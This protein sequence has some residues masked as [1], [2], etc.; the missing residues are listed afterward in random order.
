[1]KKGFTL[2]ELMGVII[3][4]SLLVLIAVPVVDKYIKQARNDAGVAQE[5]SLIMAAKN[6]A[7]DNVDQLP[8]NEGQS[9]RVNFYTLSEL[10]YLDYALDLSSF[11]VNGKYLDEYDSVKILKKNG[12][13]SYSLEIDNSVDNTAPVNLSLVLV[14]STLNTLTVKAYAEDP[15]SSIVTYEFNIDGQRESDG[16]VL[17]EGITGSRVHTF[18]NITDGE[19]TVM[20]R[21]TNLK[22]L[23]T[24]S[25]KFTFSTQDITRLEFIVKDEPNDCKTLRTVR[26][27]YPAGSKERKYKI[28]NGAFCDGVSDT[29]CNVYAAYK[30]VTGLKNGEPIT[31]S[32]TIE[33]VSLSATYTV[34]W[35]MTNKEGTEIVCK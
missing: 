13:Y 32:T 20:F 24:E 33:G 26:I 22:G 5:D 30:D 19:H 4:L 1:M 35:K 11:K 23:Q 14:S 31:A 6:W 27:I 25:K 21:A 28:G 8:E 7:S 16:S 9:I 12:K 17:W 15:E 2:I 18:K 34:R 29:S 10:G 3:I